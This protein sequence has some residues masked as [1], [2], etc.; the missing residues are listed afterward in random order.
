MEHFD[1]KTGLVLC[2]VS[3]YYC[4]DLVSPMNQARYAL[5]AV[6]HAWM[7]GASLSPGTRTVSS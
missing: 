4:T 7:N 5:C 3:S 6:Y 2:Q 1:C